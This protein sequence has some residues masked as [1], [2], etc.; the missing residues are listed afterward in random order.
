MPIER[1]SVPGCRR[2]EGVAMR[3]FTS[4]RTDKPR[5]RTRL[6]LESLESR[7][8]PTANAVLVG[9]TLT[10]TGG[11]DRDRIDVDL[12]KFAGTIVVRD[13]GLV[14]GQFA[15]AAV[16]AIDI[17]AG[18]GDDVVRIS[19]DITVPATIDGGNGNDLLFA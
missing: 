4:A 18:A 12:D 15:Q 8:L 6:R 16:T 13:A 19:A 7:T 17:Q 14:T 9:T 3:W 10:I 5:G 11:P 1:G 2:V